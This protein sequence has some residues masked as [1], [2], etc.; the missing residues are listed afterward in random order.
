MKR[1]MN[2]KLSRRMILLLSLSALVILFLSALLLRNILKGSGVTFQQKLFLLGL[3]SLSFIIY[4]ALITSVVF[5]WFRKPL[6]ELSRATAMVARGDL[7]VKLSIH[8]PREFELM[9]EIFNRMTETLKSQQH[10]LEE[11]VSRRTE[12]LERSLSELSRTQKQIIQQER[13]ASLGQLAA[14]IAH[15][16][17]NP[18]GYL[19]GNSQTL[20]D[21]IFSY[22]RLIDLYRLSLTVPSDGEEQ[23]REILNRIEE[24]EREVDFAFIRTD[25]QAL[26]RDYRQGIEKIAQIVRRL[27]T[28]ARKDE[29]RKEEVDLNDVMEYALQLVGNRLK[30]IG[31]IEKT[32]GSLPPIRAN[33]NQI[34]QVIVNL[35]INAADAVDREKGRISLVSYERN[36]EV[37]L[38]I[39]DNGC[40]MDEDTQRKIF[41]PFF[42]TK[43]AGT[44]LGLSISLDII[45]SHDGKIEVESERGKGSLFRLSFPVCRESSGGEE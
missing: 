37:Y 21:Y 43:E 36:G 14:G 12:E 19:Y 11:Q 7:S 25:L 24:L 5:S 20:A 40:G 3:L 42:T 13:L 30:N 33:K 26:I 17:N 45:N 4:A 28:Y 2:D 18:V 39:G 44:G 32:P 38:E 34:E 35:L 6:K 15:E 9:G 27:K 8:K 1:G 23:R 16:I 41:E 22:D 10:S 29:E 31:Q